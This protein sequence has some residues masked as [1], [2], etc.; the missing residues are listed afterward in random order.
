MGRV[1]DTAVGA[2]CGRYLIETL[3]GGAGQRCCG[4]GG[5]WE[6]PYRDSSRWGGSKILRWGRGCGRYLIETLA[7]GAGQ[8]YYN[9]GGVWEVPYR[10]SSRWGGSKILQWGRGVGGTL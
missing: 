10:D 2:G 4:G 6:V 9:G 1:K 5:V 3:A 7:G 8:R